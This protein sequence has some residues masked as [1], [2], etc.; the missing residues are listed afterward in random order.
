MLAG[1]TRFKTETLPVAV[2]LNISSGDFEIAIGAALWL[3]MISACLLFYYACLIGNFRMLQIQHLQV[4]ILKDISLT[5]ANGESVAIVG[6]SGSGKTTFLNAIA[7]YSGLSGVLPLSN[8]LGITS[9][10]GE[11]AHENGEDS[12]VSTLV[13]VWLIHKHPND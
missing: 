6:Q 4:G 3:L 5:V 2:Y 10:L 11:A 12:K 9:P 8:V 13:T 7:G 1:A